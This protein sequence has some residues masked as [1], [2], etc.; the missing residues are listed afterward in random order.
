[1]SPQQM[2]TTVKMRIVFVFYAVRVSYLFFTPYV[3]RICFLLYSTKTKIY[4]VSFDIVV[5]KTIAL[6][7]ACL[8]LQSLCAR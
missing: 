4:C 3:Y 8:F 7:T 5:K 2:F 1:M 6:L